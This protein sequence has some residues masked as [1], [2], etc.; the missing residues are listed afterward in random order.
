MVRHVN[1]TCVIGDTPGV[2]R[3]GVIISNKKFMSKSLFAILSLPRSGSHML[4]SALDSHPA[5]RCTG[6]YGMT[7]KFPIGLMPG[8]V[9]GCIVQS[10]HIDRGIAPPWLHD[11]KIILLNRA[12]IDIARS[13]YLND[14]HGRTATQFLSPSDSPGVQHKVPDKRLG[15]LRDQRTILL[16]YVQ[17]REHLAVS[18]KSLCG[19]GDARVI[20]REVAH[21]I[22]DF[23]DVTYHPLRPATHKP[24]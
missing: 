14:E 18:Y 24:S 10:Y 1:S 9:E 6:E 12:F 23:L 21:L 2:G 11:A 15:Y 20:R 7:E 16:N 3:A 17:D 4:A 22:C 13:Q 19:G 8:A 5:I